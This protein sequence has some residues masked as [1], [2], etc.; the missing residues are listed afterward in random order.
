MALRLS[1]CNEVKIPHYFCELKQLVYLACSD[2]F[3]NDM[4]LEFA[5]GLLGSIPLVGIFYSYSKLV[6]SIHRIASA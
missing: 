5:A 3:L 1:F 4:V 2:N 6:S